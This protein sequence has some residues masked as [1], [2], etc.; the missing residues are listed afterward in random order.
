[1]KIVEGKLESRIQ[2]LVNVDEMQL[3]F[4]PGRGTTDAFSVVKNAEGIS[5]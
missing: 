1:M 4:M 2:N 5:R 3:G